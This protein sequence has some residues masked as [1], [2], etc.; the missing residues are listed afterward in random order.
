MPPPVLQAQ[1]IT[2][3]FPG[4]LALDGVDTLHR[5]A[6]G[7]L[8]GAHDGVKLLPRRLGVFRV[9]NERWLIWAAS[10][11]NCSWCRCS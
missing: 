9:A 2:K 7:H 3:R 6:E 1:A 11:Y 4:V 8:A 5:A 10:I